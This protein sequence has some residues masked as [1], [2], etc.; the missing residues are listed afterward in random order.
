MLLIT[1]ENGTNAWLLLV[2]IG[3]DWIVWYMYMHYFI[4]TYARGCLSFV[5]W[6]SV[7]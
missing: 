6:F 5:S 7:C 4:Y 1:G 3:L 2:Q